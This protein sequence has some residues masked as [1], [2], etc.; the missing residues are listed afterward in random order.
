MIQLT[1]DQ[2]KQLLVDAWFAGHETSQYTPN[3]YGD[4][5]R[6]ARSTLKEVKED[7]SA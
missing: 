6:Y 5:N 3:A 7:V 1:E 2:L 4:A